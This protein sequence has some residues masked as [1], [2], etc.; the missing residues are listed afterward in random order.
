MRPALLAP[1]ALGLLLT[2]CGGSPGHTSTPTPLATASGGALAPNTGEVAGRLVLSGGPAGTAEQTVP[3]TIT[4]TGADGSKVSTEVDATGA[5]RVDLAPGVYRL[6]AHSP[7]AD[8][9]RILCTTDPATTRLAAGVVT[10][11]DIVC[12]IK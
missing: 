6:Q 10:Q 2:G 11:V 5:F 7:R 4:M 3:G 8:G 1:L 9:G 12:P